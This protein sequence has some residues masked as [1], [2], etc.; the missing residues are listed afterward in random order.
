MEEAIKQCIPCV[1]LDPRKQA[2]PVNM[3]TIKKPWE[4][5]SIDICASFLSGDYVIGIVDAG[6]RWPEAFVVKYTDTNTVT[7]ILERCLC[8]HSVPEVI[9]SDNGPQ[10]IVK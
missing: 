8:T 2:N 9:V 1:S 10:F 3:A 6:P 4:M 5:V 7:S